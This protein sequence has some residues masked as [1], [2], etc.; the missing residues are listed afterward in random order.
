MECLNR[1]IE[2]TYKNPDGNSRVENITSQIIYMYTYIRV[3]IYL[4]EI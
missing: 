4:I 3:R 2:I 1:K